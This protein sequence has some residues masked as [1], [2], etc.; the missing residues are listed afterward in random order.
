M[1]LSWAEL[2]LKLILFLPSLAQDREV[3][4]NGHKPTLVL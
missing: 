4:N 3:I 1:G 2:A